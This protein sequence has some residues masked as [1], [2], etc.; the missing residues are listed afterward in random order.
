VTT[1]IRYDERGVALPMAL[2]SLVLLTALMLAFASLSRT[3]PLIAAN[4]LRGSQARTLA[5]SG[6]EYAAWAL[7]NPAHPAGLPAR[8]PDAGAAAPFD[9]RTFVV[10]DRTGGFT[11]KVTNHAEGDP[12]R[13][14]LT[15]VGWTPTNSATDARPKAHRAATVDVVAVPVVGSRAPCALCVRGALTVAGNVAVD[16][17]NH[18]PACGEDTK[19][20][21]FT[22]DATTVTG[23][24]AISGGAGPGA[25][26]Q[27][28]A[29]FDAV[30]LSPAA[31]DALKTLAWRN[32]TYFGPGFPRG[33]TESDGQSTWGGRVVFDASNPL[34]DGVVFVDTTDGRNVT[35]GAA[36]LTTLAGARFEAGAFA[37]R[38]GAFRGWIV[39]NGSVDVAAGLNVAGVVYAVDGLTYRTGGSGRIDGLAVALNV[40]ETSAARIE[41]T[42]GGDVTIRFD[43][44][45]AAAA[46]LVPHGFLPIP[47]TYREDTD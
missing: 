22:R 5:E 32:G 11:I 41:A 29:A 28:A 40:G 35:A 1:P 44:G 26:H 34:R 36:A 37:T 16:G 3:E 21:T 23:A 33:G 10:L 6:L 13:R 20:G 42:P 45:R 43:C 2:M 39:V 17:G 19:Y 18:D 4:H 9:G 15:A 27:A 47:G 14:T 46:D 12:Q 30:T 38:D 31:L 24:A 8:L 7:S 25:Q